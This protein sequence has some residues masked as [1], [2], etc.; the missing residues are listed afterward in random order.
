MPAIETSNT[1]IGSLQ[2]ANTRIRQAQ[3]YDTLPIH[4]HAIPL[5]QWTFGMFSCVPWGV[6][7]AESTQGGVLMY[8]TSHALHKGQEAPLGVLC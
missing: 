6:R 1:T 5:D 8:A 4:K 7:P 2:R 3:H